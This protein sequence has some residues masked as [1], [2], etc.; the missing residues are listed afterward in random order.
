[1]T[2]MKGKYCH[3]AIKHPQH[4]NQGRKASRVLHYQWPVTVKVRERPT[5][6]PPPPV[7]FEVVLQALRQAGVAE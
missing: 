3:T 2:R 6:P 1:M 5:Y 7:R 4:R